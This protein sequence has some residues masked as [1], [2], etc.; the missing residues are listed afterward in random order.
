METEISEMKTKNPENIY[1][2]S[3]FTTDGDAE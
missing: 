3:I 1:L 2:I